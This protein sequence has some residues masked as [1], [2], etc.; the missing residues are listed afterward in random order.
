MSRD[1]STGDEVRFKG[2]GTPVM[3]VESILELHVLVYGTTL[4]NVNLLLVN[5]ISL[6][7]AN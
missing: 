5:S 3:R 6:I 1:I 2:T 7:C 4:L